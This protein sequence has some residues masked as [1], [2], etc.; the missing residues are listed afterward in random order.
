MDTTPKKE[1]IVF[2]SMSRRRH[3]KYSKLLSFYFNFIKYTQINCKIV[4]N[5]L[6][7]LG[8]FYSNFILT[9]C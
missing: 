3:R 9:K 8:C 5:Q 1:N 6:C 2:S 4:T 7:W